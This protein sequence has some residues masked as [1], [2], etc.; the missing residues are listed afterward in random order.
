MHQLGDQTQFD[1]SPEA[2]ER[3]REVLAGSPDSRVAYTARRAKKA[4]RRV[5]MR[6]FRVLPDTLPK[7]DRIDREAFQEEIGWLA[8][9]ACRGRDFAIGFR[10]DHVSTTRVQWEHERAI[11]AAGRF[12]AR[13][14]LRFCAASRSASLGRLPNVDGSRERKRR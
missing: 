5:I 11:Y 12:V 6:A 1:R 10:L 14:F 7:L 9:L 13:E 8:I 4:M 3:Y 2:A